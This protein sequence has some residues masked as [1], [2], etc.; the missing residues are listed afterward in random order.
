MIKLICFNIE[1]EK[2]VTGKV[3]KT[4][5]AFYALKQGRDSDQAY[6]SKF[7]NTVQVTK[8]CGAS[9][10]KDPL[11]GV[12]VCKDLG[13]Q[14]TTTSATKLAEITK[15]VQDYTLDAA[16]ILR[17]DPDCYNSMTQ[18]LKNPSLAGRDE[19]P[20]NVT[21]AY[22]YL[23]KWESKGTTGRGSHDYEGAAFTSQGHERRKPRD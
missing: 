8:Q 5:A 15:T 11:T 6:Q 4:K 23:S 12:M 20:K 10:G 17:A 21:E 19:W 1:D 13:L 7:L 14:V 9:L 2:Y 22:S 18:G 3:H 16:L